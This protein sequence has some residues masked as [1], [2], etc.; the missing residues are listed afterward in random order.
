MMQHTRKASGEEVA[1]AVWLPWGVITSTHRESRG[2]GLGTIVPQSLQHSRAHWIATLRPSAEMSMGP[3]NL[4]IV[5]DQ[6]R[7][8]PIS[9]TCSRNVHASDDSTVLLICLSV[10][11]SVLQVVGSAIAI[12]WKRHSDL[13]GWGYIMCR[14]AKTVVKFVRPIKVQTLLF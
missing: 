1:T 13:Y 6:R 8:Q 5:T 4:T 9:N 11:W 7:G 12:S 10:C 3:D 2:H 14:Y